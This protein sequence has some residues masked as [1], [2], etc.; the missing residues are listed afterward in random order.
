MDSSIRCEDTYEKKVN[1]YI[2]PTMYQ[3]LFSALCTCM[4]SSHF[5]Q[6]PYRGG[7]TIISISQRKEPKQ[8]RVKQVTTLVSGKVGIQNQASHVLS[9]DT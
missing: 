3:A 5:L 4:G 7:T 8:E 6:P 2:V 9:S 1:S